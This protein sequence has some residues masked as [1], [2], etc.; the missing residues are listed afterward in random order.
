MKTIL[1]FVLYEHMITLGIE[2]N[3][4][5][6]SKVTGATILFFANRYLNLLANCC[7]VIIIDSSIS[8]GAEVGPNIIQDPNLML[9]L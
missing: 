1:V 7:L 5:W 9:T 2:V 3:Y 6:S 8:F 4:F